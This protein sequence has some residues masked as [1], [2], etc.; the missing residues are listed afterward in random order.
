MDTS[1]ESPARAPKV[2][3]DIPDIV[4]SLR[5]KD[6]AMDDGLLTHDMTGLF[7]ACQILDLSPEDFRDKFF[8]LEEE[9]FHGIGFIECD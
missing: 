7:S 4:L 1:L 2:H 3:D 6:R 9:T 8:Y 5:Q